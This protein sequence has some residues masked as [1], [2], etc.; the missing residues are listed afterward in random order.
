MSFIRGGKTYSR[1]GKQCNFET[2]DQNQN[3]A[4]TLSRDTFSIITPVSAYCARNGY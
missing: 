4:I 3:V 1:K 2:D